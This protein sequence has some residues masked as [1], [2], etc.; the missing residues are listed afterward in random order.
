MNV[1]ALVLAVVHEVLDE[2][3]PV[4]LSDAATLVQHLV[5]VE[6]QTLLL[7]LL[8]LRLFCQHEFEGQVL[9]LPKLVGPAHQLF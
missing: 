6:V 3:V 7:F 1:V 8:L 9:V 4:D 2:G 5:R